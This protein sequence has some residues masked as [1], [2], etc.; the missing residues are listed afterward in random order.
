MPF[1]FPTGLY[2]TATAIFEP[3][4]QTPQSPRSSSTPPL[5]PRRPHP[6]GHGLCTLLLQ[7][8]QC[9][10]LSDLHDSS[11][12]EV[13]NLEPSHV[14]ISTSSQA[15]PP[16]VQPITTGN[17][18]MRITY[19]ALSTF[20]LQFLVLPPTDLVRLLL[21]CDTVYNTVPL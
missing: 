11:L 18:T 13:R 2:R 3:C 8:V 12:L 19:P 9:L 4:Y 20:A 15:D 7:P 1:Q 14:S 16:S 10:R 17:K 5:Y 6:L 21:L